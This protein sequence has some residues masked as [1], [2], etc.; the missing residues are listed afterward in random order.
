MSDGCSVKSESVTIQMEAFKKYFHVVLFIM[1]YD[2]VLT[3]KSVE[4]SS[5]EVAL[6]SISTKNRNL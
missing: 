4:F 3:L 2:V 6:L 5:S 1:L